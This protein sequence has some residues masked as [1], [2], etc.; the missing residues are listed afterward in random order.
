MFDSREEFKNM[1]GFTVKD[2]YNYMKRKYMEQRREKDATEQKLI[3]AKMQWA[4][5]ELERDN[6]KCTLK[7]KMDQIGQQQSDMGNLQNDLVRTKQSMGEAL[8]QAYEYERINSELLNGNGAAGA[9][10]V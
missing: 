1:A 6:L 4:N 9:A 5:L 8:N 2:K 7:Q 3:V 10:A